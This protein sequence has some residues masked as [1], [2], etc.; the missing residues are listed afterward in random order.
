MLRFTARLE[1]V[2]WPV[3]DRM[4]E[5]RDAVTGPSG[6]LPLFGDDDGGRFFQPYGRRH[7][8]GCSTG[9]KLFPDIGMAVMTAGPVHIVIDAGPFGPWSSGHSH[10][11]TLS[12]VVGIGD[13]DVLIDAGT[14]TYVGEPV[15]RERFRGSAAHNTLRID[16]RD[17]AV[18]AG[19]FGWKNQPRVKIHNWLTSDAED[20]LDAECSYAGFSHR[21]RFRLM[22]ADAVLFVSDEVTGPAGEHEV[23]QFWHLGSEQARQRMV[24]PEA[25]EEVEG[26]ASSVYGEKHR[27][28]GL[29]VV[30]RG[31]LPMRFEA[32]ILLNPSL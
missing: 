1:Q 15:E 30:K 4:V 12:F 3:L 10:S 17:Q 6:R 23:E 2:S 13:E 21:R 8:V 27:V 25:P 9:S 7:M 18:P 28:P 5:Y 31:P 24:L 14:Y 22:R 16:G 29:R 26:W 19:P 20:T 32:S 11:D